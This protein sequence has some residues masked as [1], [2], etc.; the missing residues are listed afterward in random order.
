MLHCTTVCRCTCSCG[1]DTSSNRSGREPLS[2]G[3]LSASS[4]S[5]CSVPAAWGVGSSGAWPRTSSR[6]SPGP[7]H[8]LSPR[9]GAVRELGQSHG[10][11]LPLV[12]QGSAQSSPSSP[13]GSS[14]DGLPAEVP[15]HNTSDAQR[16]VGTLWIEACCCC[17]CCCCCRCRCCC[18]SCGFHSR[19]TGSLVSS[20]G[21]LKR[22]EFAAPVRRLRVCP[23]V[24]LQPRDSSVSLLECGPAVPP[25]SPMMR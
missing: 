22:F 11:R 5:K 14:Y 4:R 6:T 16:K 2:S 17:C 18:C 7:G 15:S 1:P 3:T 24:D 8:P 19:L 25:R 12:P 10:D 20:E 21:A 13:L 9:G 23:K